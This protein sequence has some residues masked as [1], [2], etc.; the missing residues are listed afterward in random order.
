LFDGHD[1]AINLVRRLLQAA[2]AEVVHLGHNRSVAEICK[3]AVEED[4]QAVAV[5]SYQGG[6]MEFYKYLLSELSRCGAEDVLVFG[7]GGGVIL[8]EEA[9][10]LQEAGVARIYTSED[11]R[12]LGLEGMIAEVVGLAQG[13]K[14]AEPARRALEDLEAG[15]RTGGLVLARA[16]TALALGEGPEMRAEPAKSPVVIGVTGSGGAGKSCLVDELLVRLL[17]DEGFQGRVAVLAI[18]PARRRGGALLGDR[19]RVNCS[20]DPRVFFRS[21]AVRG[22]ASVP[23][24]LAAAIR[25]CGLAGFELVVVET[26]GV[27]QGADEVADYADL[28]V[29][30]MTPEFGSP[31]QLEKVS[32]LD[33]AD[34]VA[35]NKADRR[36]ADDAVREVRRLLARQPR[37]AGTSPEDLPVVPTVASRVF[38][39]GVDKLYAKLRC[40]LAEMGLIDAGR[41]ADLRPS[42][43]SSGAAFLPA[44]ATDYLVRIAQAVRSY[45]ARTAH[46]E[47]VAACLDAID[48]T[49]TLLGPEPDS[50]V[51]SHLGKARERFSPE[52][53]REVEDCLREWEEARKVAA[54]APVATTLSG[55]EVS[56]VA[57]PELAET[58]STS[59]K[60]RFVRKENVPG[61]FPFTNGVFPFRRDEDPTRLFA[62]E[63]TPERTNRRL[64]YLAKG[65][66]GKRLSIAFDSVTLYGEDPDTRPDIY[67]KIGNSGVSVATIEDMKELFAGF[68]LASPDT[69]VSM[70]INGPAPAILAMFFNTAIDQRID[71]QERALGRALS[72]EEKKGVAAEVLSTIRGTVQADVLKE[73]QAQNTCIFSTD[74][75]LRM[76]ADMEEWFI[77]QKVRHFYSVSV[78]GYH[79]A[80]AGANPVTQLAF[81]LANGFTYV[82]AYLARGMRVD[83]FAKH[84][85]FF[86]SVGM[87]PE[88]SVLGRVARRIWAIAIR[89]VYG[90]GE[91]S[92]KLKYHVQ[93]SGRSLHAQEMEFNDIR[94]TLQALSALYDNCNSLHTNA[95]DEAVTTPTEE[96]VRR[97]LAIQLIINREWGLRKCDNPLAGSYLIEKLTDLVEEAVLEEF[98]RLAERGGVLGA[99]ELGYQRRR[100]QEESARYEALKAS[101]QLPVIGVNTFVPEGEP[102]F[103]PPSTLAR[104]S[105][106]EKVRQIRRVTEFKERH[107][108]E[109]RIALAHLRDVA[110][111]GGNTFEALMRATRVATLG[112]ITGALYEVGGRYRR[113]F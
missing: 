76:M 41:S 113:S 63:G 34:L 48:T 37:F 13:V 39:E 22:A 1:A 24:Y 28:T 107:R 15:S 19:L 14:K 62:G 103:K 32:V 96:S 108:Q 36:G 6:H 111:S 100:I 64:H 54:A 55:T 7:G 110:E 31:L 91:R 49:A 88:Y 50:Q 60:V 46:L 30:V 23:P 112:Q 83:D 43:R 52:D 66:K 45:R 102:A 16:L 90:G 61:R 38:D 59:A 35:V 8:P 101:G 75:A 105:E 3:A 25:A 69:S 78:S 29:Y 106:E 68:D 80:E 18:D 93:T 67:G 74:F 97:A 79:I 2:G 5:S 77:R 10:E 73:D 4:V 44:Q 86:F 12:Q 70:T 56:S 85:S 94:T 33:C 17:H 21:V 72:E 87:D 47:R 99:M 89:D 58:G 109:A 11:A 95:F 20:S 92:Q 53:V 81:T 98:E 71:R 65:I 40:A 82:E 9:A 57:A 51:A 27:G 104:S 26:P 84:L 42:P